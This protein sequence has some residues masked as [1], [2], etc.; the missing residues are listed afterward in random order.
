METLRTP[1][2]FFL[3]SISQAK[4]FPAY[5]QGPCLVYIFTV[6]KWRQENLDLLYHIYIFNLNE[7]HLK[8]PDRL[9]HAA[10][11]GGFSFCACS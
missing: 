6:L 1:C 3:L 4:Q 11:S 10:A 5:C 2:I 8:I 7:L 9:V